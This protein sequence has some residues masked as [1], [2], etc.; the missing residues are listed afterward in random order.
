MSSGWER[1]AA[2]I[3]LV[4]AMLVIALLIGILVSLRTTT[5]VSAPLY[6]QSMRALYAAHAGVEYAVRCATDPENRAKYCTDP[7]G[8]IE[9][10]GTKTLGEASFA[11]KLDVN[12]NILMSV[13]RAG[14]AQ[15]SIAV[16]NFIDGFVP[17]CGGDI[18]LVSYS[19]SGTT[20]YY[21]LRNNA[22]CTLRITELAIA[23]EGGQQ[24]EVSTLVINNTTVWNS[25]VKISQ[26][27]NNPTF[28]DIT[29]CD[30]PTGTTGQ[31]ANSIRVKKAGQKSGTWYITFYYRG[32]CIGENRKITIFFT[33]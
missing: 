16:Q 27:R 7:A 18:V 20:V 6:V 30:L 13:G 11:L 4:F 31:W 28:L 32:F 15:R 3:A 2:L 10:I 5:T 17:A 8:F 9:A 12:N 29:D 1:G 22:T 23:K 33:L 14:N 26:N 21:Q 24:A 19:G 25:P